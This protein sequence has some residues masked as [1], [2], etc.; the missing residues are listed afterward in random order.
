MPA[1]AWPR[2]RPGYVPL[3]MKTP[4]HDFGLGVLTSQAI[5]EVIPRNQVLGIKGRVELGSL[6][7]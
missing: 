6:R 2:Q 3:P 7:R 5:D 4:G 1:E